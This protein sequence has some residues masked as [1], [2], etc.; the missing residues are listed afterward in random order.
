ME[1]KL[2]NIKF[3]SAYNSDPKV[4]GSWIQRNCS[5]MPNKYVYLCQEMLLTG[6]FQ[7]IDTLELISDISKCY[8]EHIKGSNRNLSER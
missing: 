5:Q 2:L 7:Y 4:L 6:K 3:F 1:E 8:E